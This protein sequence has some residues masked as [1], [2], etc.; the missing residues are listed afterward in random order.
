[1]TSL[2]NEF[3][4]RVDFNSYEDF[5]K[6]FKFKIRDDFNFAYDVV[7]K[8]AEI[9]PEKLALLWCDNQ[10]ERRFTFKDIKKYSNQLA[11]FLRSLG[12][13]KG[14]NVILTLKNRY[15]WWISMMALHKIGAV[16][17]PATHM[18]KL[19]DINYRIEKSEAI[20]VISIVEDNLIEDYT[21]SEK[22]LGIDLKKIVVSD[23]DID[24]WYNFH[25]EI[26]KMS[27]VYK[28]PV[29]TDQDTKIT[30][31][32]LIYFS[33]GTSGNPKMVR[34]DYHYVLGHIVTAKYWH[35]VVEEGLHHSSADTGWGKAVWGNLYGQWIA[36]SA[37]FIYDYVRFNG[38]E[39]LKQ[40]TKHNVTTFCAPP[41]IYR[42][43]IK[44]DLSN[45]DFSSIVNA[46]TAGEPLPPEVFNRF[47]EQT[48]LEIRESFGQ[49]ETVVALATFKWLKAKQGS[50]GKP[51]PV[52]GIEL[53]DKNGEIV[54]IG[55]EG[56]ITFKLD[57]PNVGLFKEY[58]KNPEKNQ[59]VQYNNHYHS[60]DTAWMDEEGYYHFVGRND[61]IIKSSG[62]RIGPYE[63]ESAVI[64]HPSV[65]ECAITG[66]PDK[67]RGQIVKATIVLTRGYEASDEL[68][69]E[70]QNHVK[71]VTA[72]YKY[73]RLIEFVD[74]LPKTISGKIQ[75]KLI[76]DEDNK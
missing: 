34:H 1:M 67:Q 14:D 50:V 61:D 65:L 71:K 2:I 75:R 18:L 19:H 8:Y 4:E 70:I 69:K 51:N 28:R 64:S 43:L 46:T 56:E 7:D 33:S 41:T 63:V 12:I 48:G 32:L 72:P 10:E 11:N 25:K 5:R 60:G 59:E 26:S 15:E 22:D 35:E 53:L 68:G 66:Y 36:G 47:K 16:A 13:N 3:V 54:D 42:F 76:R 30:D 20:A 62:Y 39:L 37:V 45:F 29:G 55:D 49:T 17:I 6:N 52:F 58:Y 31:T 40:I 27:D 57:S 9:D 73:P 23:K 24:G 21:Q 44:E 38:L 74:E